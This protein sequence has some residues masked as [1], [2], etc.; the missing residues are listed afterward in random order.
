MKYINERILSELGADWNAL[1]NT[2]EEATV[3]L[4]EKQISQPIKPYLRFNNPVNRII[5]MPAFVGGDFKAAGIKWIASFP[6]N[7]KRS[8]KR[9]HAV[10]IL[11]DVETGIPTTLVNTALISGIR[12]ASVSGLILKKYIESNNIKDVNCGIIGFGPIGQLHFE[13]LEGLL[14]DKMKHV[15]VYDLNEINKDLISRYGKKIA[16][17][18]NWREVYEKSSILITCTVS[19]D[20]Y[21]DMKPKKG[22]VYL[23]VS[24]RDF[25]T[26]FV[27]DIDVNVVDSWEEI[28]RE[29]TDIENAHKQFGLA[30]K[31]VFEITDVLKKDVMSALETKSFMFNPMGMAIYDI[32]IAKYYS[33]LAERKNNYIELED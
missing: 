14:G 18:D 20:R 28:C 5:A 10:M 12:T 15:F 31:D 8:I 27:K 33:D 29:N 21:I 17:C 26:D 16:V 24:L 11:N 23:N 3:A 2:I 19:S 7:I 22:G 9:A 1:I 13:M 30:K 4:K 6:D 32:A 25:Q